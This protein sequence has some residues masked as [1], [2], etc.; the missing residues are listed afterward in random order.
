VLDESAPPH[1]PDAPSVLIDDGQLERWLDDVAAELQRVRGSADRVA[2]SPARLV[3]AGTTRSADAATALIV[4]REA[5]ELR[6]WARREAD[7]L[8]DETRRQVLEI[9]ERLRVGIVDLTE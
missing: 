9:Y 1:L 4:S 6:D 2:A 3:E 8:V 7:A 5:G